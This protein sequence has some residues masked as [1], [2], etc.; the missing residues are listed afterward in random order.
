VLDAQAAL[1]SAA[2]AAAAPP[3]APRKFGETIVDPGL[4]RRAPVVVLEPE[5]RWPA[6]PMLA[7]AALLCLGLAVAGFLFG[8]S[9]TKESHPPLGVAVA[10]PVS[11]S[12]PTTHWHAVRP[13]R[14]R[15]LAL[16]NPVALAG[17]G[18]SLLAGIDPE[19]DPKTLLP[20]AFARTLAKAPS[21][22]HVLLGAHH[23]LRYR[24]RSKGAGPLTVYAVPVGLGSALVVCRGNARALELCESAAATL[25]LRGVRDETIG[26]NA[27]YA[28]ALNAVLG[29]LARVRRSER[30][31]LAAG[32]SAG[33]RAGHAEVLAS[34][35]ATTEAQ[36]A[37]LL[38]GARERAAQGRLAAALAAARDGYV[39]LAA[40]LRAGDRVTYLAAA[41]RIARAEG[42]AD[43]A[44]QSLRALGYRVKTLR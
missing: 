6:W 30:R 22:E 25:V 28:A 23:A 7:V 40:A 18:A 15:G 42:A 16:A 13:P 33:E 43:A 11:L 5:R 19:T 44:V 2:G 41:K 35:L 24:V 34:Q 3:P 38:P 4:R 20:A 27:R 36:I 9:R 14:V 26:P 1:G 21:G 31:A 32:K 8:H 10:G 29:R 39:T 17:P 12:F 37:S